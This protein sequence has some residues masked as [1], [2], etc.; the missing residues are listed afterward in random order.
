MK[1][2]ILFLIT[3]T[4]LC[5]ELHAEKFTGKDFQ[6]STN[7]IL[8]SESVHFPQ[9]NLYK[10]DKTGNEIFTFYSNPYGIEKLHNFQCGYLSYNDTSYGISFL[11]TGID[12]YNT[13]EFNLFFANEIYRFF[14]F[15]SNFKIGSLNYNTDSSKHSLYSDIDFKVGGFIYSGIF[16]SIEISDLYYSAT[17]CRDFDLLKWGTALSVKPFQGLLIENGF[18]STGSGSSFYSSF[19]CALRHEIIIYSD[20]LFESNEIRTGL[21]FNRGLFSINYCLRYHPVLG[22]THML[23]LTYC[24]KPQKYNP[25]NYSSHFTGKTISKDDLIDLQICTLDELTSISGI[26]KRTAQNIINIRKLHGELT[27]YGLKCAGCSTSQIDTLIMYSANPLKE[28]IEY[29]RENKKKNNYKAKS[30]KKKKPDNRSKP[31]S[32]VKAK[33]LFKDLTAA[34]ISKSCSFEICRKSLKY[35]L[36]GLYGYIDSLKNLNPTEKTKAKKICKKYYQ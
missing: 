27:I 12:Y 35:S 19:Q 8:M 13:S 31:I 32:E 36:Y 2:K 4:T 18:K 17:Q 6:L 20:Y 23:K 11:Y 34:G 28:K 10:E 7:I 22:N 16:Y 26:D 29:P 1:V 15:E 14:S 3:L 30:I 21:I 9:L 5:I 25:V 33:L 24:S